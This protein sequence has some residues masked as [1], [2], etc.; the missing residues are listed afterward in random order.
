MYE[1]YIDFGIRMCVDFCYFE[2]LDFVERNRGALF[3]FHQPRPYTPTENNTYHACE[4]HAVYPI[5]CIGQHSSGS[6]YMTAQQRLSCHDGVTPRSFCCSPR[7]DTGHRGQKP[8]VC[9]CD[10]ACGEDSFRCTKPTLVLLVARAK[11]VS[12]TEGQAGETSEA[13]VRI[14]AQEG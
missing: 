14:C 9:L 3:C 5:R 1:D 10:L 7:L 6:L 12:H 8:N 4:C 13:N 2:A 11:G